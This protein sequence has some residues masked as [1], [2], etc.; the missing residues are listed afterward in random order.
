M[1]TSPIVS[2]IAPAHNAAPFFAAWLKSIRAQEYECIEVLLVDDGSTDDLAILAAQ[3]PPFLRYSRQDHRGPAAARNAAIRSASGD[4]IAFLDLDDLWA[5]EHLRRCTREL[6]RN[7]AAGIA[8]GLIRNT[9]E[10]CYCSEPYRFINL[11]AGVFRRWVFDRC[12]L[13]DETLRFAEDFDFMTRCWDY[14]I[15]KLDIEEV[16]LL[17]HRHVGNMTRGLSNVDL[18][19]VRVYKRRLDRVRAGQ[20]DLEAARGLKIGFPQYIGCPIIPHDQGLREP[21]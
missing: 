7:P 15:L 18:G 16:S 19:A 14:G 3:A 4:L 17:Y 12:G 2:I 9:C 21:I 8:Q 10:G 11:G 5:P 1:S 20:V 6:D 13:L